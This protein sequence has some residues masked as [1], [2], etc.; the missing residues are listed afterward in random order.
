M[1]IP[2]LLLYVGNKGDILLFGMLENEEF[3]TKTRKYE[4]LKRGGQYLEKGWAIPAKPQAA[5]K[6]TGTIGLCAANEPSM[7]GWQLHCHPFP[8][9]AVQLPHQRWFIDYAKLNNLV[10]DVLGASGG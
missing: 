9:A 4:T 5:Y 3:I 7:L 6:T 8:G 1:K 2:T 10:V